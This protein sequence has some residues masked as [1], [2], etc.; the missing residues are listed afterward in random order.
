MSHSDAG[1]VFV[2]TLLVERVILTFQTFGVPLTG[3]RLER[4]RSLPAAY[5]HRL[6]DVADKLE[7]G[8]RDGQLKAV[9][10]I[11]QL[12]W[13]DMSAAAIVANGGNESATN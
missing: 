4:V 8:D 9:D 3:A 11:V 5:L 7:S 1:T 6:V 10:D 2:E 12:Y 13:F